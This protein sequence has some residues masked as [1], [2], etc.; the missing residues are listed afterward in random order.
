MPKKCQGDPYRDMIDKCHRT[1]DLDSFNNQEKTLES[2]TVIGLES[3]M[4]LLIVKLHRKIIS[5]SL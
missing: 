1:K 4:H 2:N 3:K 5:R